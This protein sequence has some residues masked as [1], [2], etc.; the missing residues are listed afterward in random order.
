MKY[1]FQGEEII[2]PLVKEAFRAFIIGPMRNVK[3]F[4]FLAQ[5]I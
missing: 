3:G 4:H 1:L 2:S 5:V